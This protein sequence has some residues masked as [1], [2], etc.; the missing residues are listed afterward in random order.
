M[1]IARRIGEWTVARS[2]HVAEGTCTAL[3]QRGHGQRDVNG[4]ETHATLDAAE[5]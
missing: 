1:G 4:S 5:H 3:D 2:D